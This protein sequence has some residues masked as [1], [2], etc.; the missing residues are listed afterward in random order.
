MNN[1]SS[2]TP[3]IIIF[4]VIVAMVGGYIYMKSAGTGTTT[5][6]PLTASSIS[7]TT[8]KFQNIT[9]QLSSISFDTS[10]FSDLRFTALQDI[11]T[12]VAQE[13]VGRTDP[14][15]PLQ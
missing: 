7:S 1:E 6:Q 2:L 8:S 14:F 3:S 13:S 4:I 10:I 15:A 9:N 11:T 5:T 12:P